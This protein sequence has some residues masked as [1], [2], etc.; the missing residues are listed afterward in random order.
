MLSTLRPRSPPRHALHSSWLALRGRIVRPG[1]LVLLVFGTVS[2][3][4]IIETLLLCIICHPHRLR[5]ESSRHQT[6]LP[7]HSYI[8]VFMPSLCSLSHVACHDTF[9]HI[10]A[11]LV[12]NVSQPPALKSPSNF[13][14]IA[15]QILPLSINHTSLTSLSYLF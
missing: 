7:M 14:A 15:L 12:Y 11:S 2:G 13:L 3:Y 4:V 9:S 6:T 5:S 8:H 10:S 1:T